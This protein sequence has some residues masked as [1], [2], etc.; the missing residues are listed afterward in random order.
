MCPDESPD[1]PPPRRGR[2]RCQGTS[3]P[4]LR[5]PDNSAKEHNRQTPARRSI[6]SCRT[7][8]AGR[9]LTSVCT[10]RP[11]TPS[12]HLCST[13]SRERP[14]RCT[15][16]RERTSEYRSR[17]LRVRGMVPRLCWRRPCRPHHNRGTPLGPDRVKPCCPQQPR[18]RSPRKQAVSSGRISSSCFTSIKVRSLCRDNRL[19]SQGSA[20]PG[21]RSPTGWAHRGLPGR[22]ASISRSHPRIRHAIGS[23]HRDERD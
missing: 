17:T 16:G 9:V 10:G 12:H 13:V 1:A 6:R 21:D 7:S 18:R 5:V 22:F 23:R 15:A 4:G 19:S 8:R 20:T 2:I 14:C 11:N 3:E